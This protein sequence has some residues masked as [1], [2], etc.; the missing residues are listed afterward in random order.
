VNKERINQFVEEYMTVLEI[1][2]DEDAPLFQVENAL[3]VMLTDFLYEDRLRTL[4]L[5]NLHKIKTSDTV[6]NDILGGTNA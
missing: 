3:R 1:A 2:A 5:L 6:K 4:N